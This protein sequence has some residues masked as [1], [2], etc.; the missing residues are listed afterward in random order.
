[1]RGDLVRFDPVMEAAVRE[2]RLARWQKAL[3]AA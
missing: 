2:E 3:A 1:M